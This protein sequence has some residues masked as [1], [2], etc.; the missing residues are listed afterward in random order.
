MRIIK[1]ARLKSVK[2]EKSDS[3]I[4]FSEKSYNDMRQIDCYIVYDIIPLLRDSQDFVRPEILVFLY[5]III[6]LK[7]S[8]LR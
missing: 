7:I 6:T 2:I 4:S 3:Y 1:S 5:F 8:L